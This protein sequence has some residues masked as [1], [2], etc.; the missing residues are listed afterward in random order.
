MTPCPPHP[1]PPHLHP[2]L[3]PSSVSVNLLSSR[4]TSLTL[5]SSLFSHPD[6][7][8]RWSGLTQRG[9]PSVLLSSVASLPSFSPSYCLEKQKPIPW[10]SHYGPRG[11]ASSWQSRDAGSIPCPAQWV[12]DLAL[13]QLQLRLQQWLGSDSWPRNSIFLCEAK[14]KKPPK[15][16]QD[17]LWWCSGNESE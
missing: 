15:Q 6:P 3:L 14:T 9:L 12:K 7:V 13:P 2:H 1:T 10:R 5:S 11:L 4:I 8:V 16:Q 17:F